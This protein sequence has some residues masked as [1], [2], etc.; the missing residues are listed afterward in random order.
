M[1]SQAD[2][3]LRPSRHLQFESAEPARRSCAA[4]RLVRFHFARR[5][6]AA[7]R[8]DPDRPGQ[9]VRLDAAGDPAA[10]NGARVAVRTENRAAHRIRAVQRSFAGQRR[11]YDRRTIRRTCRLSRAACWAPWAGRRSRR[12]CRTAPIDATVAANQTFTSG[13]RAGAAFLRVAAGE[14]ATCLPPVSITAVPDGKLHAPYFM[15]WSFGLEH[16]FGN[17]VN[18]RGAV[19]GHARGESALSDASERLS[20]RVPGMLCAV[21]LRAADRS[22]ASARSRSFAPARTATTTACK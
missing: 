1:T 12:E 7:E 14:S 10:E 8:R 3:D 4:S 22:R 18:L 6:S 19:C 17:T 21:S 9:C 20:D 5:E 16:Q 2:L 15:E 13:F 11:G